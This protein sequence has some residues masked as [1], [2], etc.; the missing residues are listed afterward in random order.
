MCL[1][2]FKISI[3]TVVNSLIIPFNFCSN[4]VSEV[5]YYYYYYYYYYYCYCYCYYYY[6]YLY[7]HRILKKFSRN[8][9][10][11]FDNVF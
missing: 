8:H 3:A 4:H 2:D 11:F 10:T 7:F 1:F 5:F 6:Y 9:F